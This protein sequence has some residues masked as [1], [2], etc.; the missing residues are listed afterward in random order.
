[1]NNT[2]FASPIERKS[3]PKLW[4]DI[5]RVKT[6]LRF[7]VTTFNWSDSWKKFSHHTKISW[8]KREKS[9]TETLKD[10]STSKQQHIWCQKPQDSAKYLKRQNTVPCSSHSK[11]FMAGKILE[12]EWIIYT[13]AEK[14]E[15]REKFE[16][17]ELKHVIKGVL[18]Q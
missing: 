7:T 15:E 1:M 17:F 2:K 6:G 5:N 9:Q 4:W 10:H 11:T 16:I 3:K 12:Y 18:C 14:K 13:L 8:T